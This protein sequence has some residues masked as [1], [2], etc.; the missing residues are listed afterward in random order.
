MNGKQPMSAPHRWKRRLRYAVGI[1]TVLAGFLLGL[2]GSTQHVPEFYREALADANVTVASAEEFQARTTELLERME[3]SPDWT[4]SFTEQQINSWLAYEFP[5]L[6][7]DWIPAEISQPR[8]HF[9]EGTVLTACRYEGENFSGVLNLKIRPRITET[10]ELALEL[11]SVKAG[12]L[13]IPLSR[14][15]DE[16]P[17]QS[18]LEGLSVKLV[19]IDGQDTLLISH[20]SDRRQT[21]ELTKIEIAGEQITLSGKSLSDDHPRLSSRLQNQAEAA[22]EVSN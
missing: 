18:D 2:Y 9:Q 4:E 22:S 16:L 6:N 17:E 12:L 5:K 15:L 13:P 10:H 11:V 14:I 20:E 1:A 21:R 19:D 7:Q 8:V 3:E